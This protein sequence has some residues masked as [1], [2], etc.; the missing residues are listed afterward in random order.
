MK[1]GKAAITCVIGLAILIMAYSFS[2]WYAGLPSIDF[3][4]STEDAIDTQIAQDQAATT[5]FMIACSIGHCV[6]FYGVWKFLRLQG[7]RLFAAVIS[8]TFWLYIANTA[9][10]ILSQN[11]GEPS[12]VEYY[13]AAFAVVLGILEYNKVFLC[14]LINEKWN[15]NNKL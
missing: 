4:I 15:Q 5:F 13:G 6:I 8:L 3:D 1:E 10:E 14:K 12:K 7:Y 9:D 11:T 2:G